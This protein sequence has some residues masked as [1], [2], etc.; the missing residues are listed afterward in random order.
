[1]VTIRVHRHAVEVLAK[2]PVQ[3]EIS[4]QEVEAAFEDDGSGGTVDVHRHAVETLSKVPV[5]SNLSRQELEAAFE[6]DGSGGT[7]RIHRH[8]I[9]VLAKTLAQTNLS[10]Q[11][12]EAAFA[13]AGSGA[14]VLVHRQ[15]I[16]ILAR[17]GVPVPT[18]LPFPAGLDFFLHN[19]VSLMTLET[20]YRTDITRS[21]TTLA[22]ERRAL[23]QRPGRQIGLSLLQGTKSEL[24]RLYVYLRRL[25]TDRLVSPLFMDAV[26]LTQ[27]DLGQDRIF[28]DFR[29]RRYFEGARVAVF[30][31]NPISK[32]HMLPAEIDVYTIAAITGADLQL[33]RDLDNAYAN[34]QFLVVPLIDLELVLAPNIKQLTDDTSQVTL[35]LNE[36]TG[37]NALPPSFTGNLV[38]GWEHDLGLPVLE[39]DQD[40]TNGIN[41]TYRR[42]GKRRTEGR[43][44][45]VA[46]EG[47]RYVQVQNFAL[48]LDRPDFWRVLNLFDS[49]R[50]RTDLFWEIDREELWTVSLVAAQTVTISPVGVFADFDADFTDHLGIVMLDGT[51]H[52]RKINTITDFGGSWLLSLVNGNDLPAIDPALIDRFS[53]ARQKRF[54]SDAMSERW[55]TTETVEIQFATVEVLNEK[56]IDI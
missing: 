26:L 48:K 18:P 28:G 41:T 7:A 39:I 25:T 47:D 11:E 6:D 1:M 12:I 21:P 17:P 10:R 55:H 23:L 3:S 45:V 44:V 42:Y 13:D 36:V 4:R 19:W 20:S 49:R 56:E 38:D 2:A 33:D 37:K 9:E 8:A 22:E 40:W 31:A 30:P 27:S 5:Q 29:F 16:E 51:I 32:S 35:T 24:D 14:P 50:G 54:D 53:R 46:P 34:K 15:G 52:I 43:G